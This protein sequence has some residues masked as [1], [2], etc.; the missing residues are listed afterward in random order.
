LAELG[1]KFNAVA[2]TEVVAGDPLLGTVYSA[3]PLGQLQ[4]GDT[5]NLLYYVQKPEVITPEP[6]P[7]V[8]TTP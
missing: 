4:T 7:S 2:G 6:T 5:V 1:L 3:E 8:S